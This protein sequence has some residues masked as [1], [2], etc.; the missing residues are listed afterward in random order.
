MDAV[1]RRR[2]GQMNVRATVLLTI[3]VLSP[4]LAHAQ[5]QYETL[6]KGFQ[7]E[8]LYHF[9]DLDQ[10]NI[11]NGNLII[12]IPIGLTYP[13]NGGLTYNLVLSYNSNVWDFELG[14]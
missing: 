8:K 14:P 12:N 5:Q 13:L 11:F 9:N 4:S 6:Q 1:R 10:V 7:P 3:L 2:G